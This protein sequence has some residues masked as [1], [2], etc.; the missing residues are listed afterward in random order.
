MADDEAA[1]VVAWGAELRAVHGRLRDAL[2]L[3]RDSA[4]QV[5]GGADP[6]AATRELLMFCRGFC[7]A[8]A[9][10][11]TSEDSALFPQIRA[12]HPEL[13]GLL[14]K[15]VQDH[16]MIAYLL[17][18]LEHA[19][20]GTPSAAEL[21]RHLDGIGAIMESHFRYEETQLLG[22]LDALELDASKERLL[23]PL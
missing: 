20:H 14:D 2:E 17:T 9:G 6:L 16:S 18:E 23:G 21:E 15:L 4:G 7:T 19:A 13:G 10:H 3:V 22:V 12:Q 5:A 1:R 11:H 8:L